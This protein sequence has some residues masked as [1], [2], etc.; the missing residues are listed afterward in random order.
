M[1]TNQLVKIIVSEIWCF[2]Y[3]APDSEN[4]P[5]KHIYKIS[6]EI[7]LSIP[8]IRYPM[9]VSMNHLKWCSYVSDWALRAV[10]TIHTVRKLIPFHSRLGLVFRLD[11]SNRPKVTLL[12][13]RPNYNHIL[14]SDYSFRPKHLYSYDP[15]FWA[16]MVS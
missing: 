11:H 4:F 3:V 8:L 7:S 10:R 2:H 12:Y 6:I 15:E 9:V 1:D 13:S 14:V 16:L 5:F